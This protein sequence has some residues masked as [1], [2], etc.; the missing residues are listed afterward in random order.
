VS[1]ACPAGAPPIPKEFAVRRLPF[2]AA[3]SKS[4]FL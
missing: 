3:E 2:T 1:T 4:I